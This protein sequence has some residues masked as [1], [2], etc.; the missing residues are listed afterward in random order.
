[1]TK[2]VFTALDETRKSGQDEFKF[3]RET[4]EW[5]EKSQKRLFARLNPFQKKPVRA[6]VQSTESQSANFQT[7]RA[8]AFDMSPLP[9]HKRGAS[10]FIG[11]GR[12]PLI[13]PAAAVAAPVRGSIAHRPFTRAAPKSGSVAA[14]VASLYKSWSS[15]VEQEETEAFV[16]W[17]FVWADAHFAV[18]FRHTPATTLATTGL[19]GK[20]RVLLNGVEVLQQENKV[21][22]ELR[23]QRFTVNPADCGFPLDFVV[24]PVGND[25]ELGFSYALYLDRSP[26][27]KCRL[28]WVRDK[29]GK[30]LRSERGPDP[31][32]L[33]AWKHFVTELPKGAQ[34]AV[35]AFTVDG[36]EHSAVLVK[37]KGKVELELDRNRID[38]EDPVHCVRRKAGFFTREPKVVRFLC[39]FKPCEITIEKDEKGKRSFNLTVDGVPFYVFKWVLNNM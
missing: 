13:E 39:N 15:R 7:G 12:G 17:S 30:Q 34:K 18:E 28:R 36:E 10:F 16:F 25:P 22:A 38:V 23:K 32:E 31:K 8:G 27:E 29:I 26:F 1:M 35:Y 37:K 21:E 14:G 2:K 24:E 5:A 6:A 11:V 4:S 20:V 19:R 9:Q 33:G 3:H